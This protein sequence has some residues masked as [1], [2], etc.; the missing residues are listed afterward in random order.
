MEIYAKII[1]LVPL[2]ISLITCGI[3]I[4]TISID[5]RKYYDQMKINTK[6]TVYTELMETTLDMVSKVSTLYPRS[7]SLSADKEEQQKFWEN[8][9]NL[10]KS[11]QSLCGKTLNKYSFFLD[12]ETDDKFLQ[13]IKECYVQI[14]MFREERIL[15]I[16][17]YDKLEKDKFIRSCRINGEKIN[18]ST[19]K[20]IDYMRTSVNE[21]RNGK[22]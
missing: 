10:A 6:F 1:E 8:N 11:S 4:H 21:L 19:E 2:I 5:R 12:K 20:L 22:N 3:T 15:G 14:E 18:E 17:D 16:Y 9:Y 13:I 7:S